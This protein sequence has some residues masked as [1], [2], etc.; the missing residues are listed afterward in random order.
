LILVLTYPSSSAVFGVFLVIGTFVFATIRAYYKPL[1]FLSTFGTIAIDIFCVRRVV[2]VT[3]NYR[4]L[5][6]YPQTIGPLFPFAEYNLLNSLLIPVS[7]Y[8]AIAIVV[9]IFVFPQTANHAFLGIVTLLLGQM[10][11]LLDAQEDLLTA[12]PGSISPESPKILQLKAIRASMFTIHQKCAFFPG[13]VSLSV[14]D[15]PSLKVTQM[16]KFINAEFSWGRWNGDDARQLEEPLLG[17]ISRL[18]G[19]WSPSPLFS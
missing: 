2:S 15:H 14:S 7:I 10:K 17:V 18:S 13:S 19:W 3:L 12:V 5:I 4:L 9:T 11:V 16:G 8:M 1:I 6:F